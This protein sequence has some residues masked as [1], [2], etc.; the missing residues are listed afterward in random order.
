MNTINRKTIQIMNK[1]G[2][3]VTGLTS[4]TFIDLD[5]PKYI[6]NAGSGDY[7]KV[8]DIYTLSAIPG[9]GNYD[10]N[11][12]SVLSVSQYWEHNSTKAIVFSNPNDSVNYTYFSGIEELDEGIYTI[13]YDFA[14]TPIR[15][16]RLLIGG[17]ATI[18]EESELAYSVIIDYDAMA[19]FYHQN[20]AL[21]EKIIVR[22][23]EIIPPSVPDNAYDDGYELVPLGEANY[24]I[25][26]DDGYPAIRIKP[27]WRVIEPAVYKVS[28]YSAT[29]KLWLE[30]NGTDLNKLKINFKELGLDSEFEIP[31]LDSNYLSKPD[32][33]ALSIANMSHYKEQVNIKDAITTQEQRT[34]EAEKIVLESKLNSLKFQFSTGS[35]TSEV[36]ASAVDIILN[37]G[38]PVAGGDPHTPLILLL[39]K[40]ISLQMKLITTL[41]VN[42]NYYVVLTFDEPED[43][44]PSNPIVQYLL[45]YSI[46]EK[47]EF[48]VREIVV[49]DPDTN[50][51][52]NLY[53]RKVVGVPYS[54]IRLDDPKRPELH[55]KISFNEHYIYS[56]RR[57]MDISSGD[58]VYV[59]DTSDIRKFEFEVF[60]NISYKV[61]IAAIADNGVMSNWSNLIS[62]VPVTPLTEETN[63]MVNIGSLIDLKYDK[64]LALPEQGI[65]NRLSAL[66]EKMEG[67]V[68][69]SANEAMDASWEPTPNSGDTIYDTWVF[70][71]SLFKYIKAYKYI[72]IEPY[73]QRTSN[74]KMS[75]TYTDPYS[76]IIRSPIIVPGD[77][78]YWEMTSN[79]EI[80]FNKIWFYGTT[81][82][83]AALGSAIDGITSQTLEFAEIM[84][85]THET[86]FRKKLNSFDESGIA[87]YMRF[88][89]LILS[90]SEYDLYLRT[91]NALTAQ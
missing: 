77:E 18:D 45:E 15:R 75:W 49:T 85:G 39:E 86:I 19:D 42:D 17:G 4:L 90:D 33:P 38:L 43:P 50:E 51:I 78:L 34:Y 88:R 41:N 36:Y 61:R 71:F 59:T 83:S 68:T 87:P 69:D 13:A 89:L 91:K 56:K 81:A 21:M 32:A 7:D 9:T 60:P 47:T 57:T 10:L 84:A 2:Q 11:P 64:N 20:I 70:K 65:E 25:P 29:S 66:E 14:D 48:N 31:L 46:V 40:I 55:N 76:E 63:L 27:N 44:H 73:I 58:R 12:L 62:Y 80:L 28:K 37:Q 24:I 6:L 23:L 8:D 3:F 67:Y 16:I 35:I 26:G 54:G 82:L 5:Q 1:E 74:L 53:E 52:I 72:V 22:E 30:S 79:D